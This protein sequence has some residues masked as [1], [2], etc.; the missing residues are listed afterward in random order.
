ML[1]QLHRLDKGDRGFQT[2]GELRVFDMD[3]TQIGKVLTTVEPAWQQNRQNIS[4][5][6]NGKFE[7]VKRWS[8]RY[9]NHFH[10][11]DIYG[12]SLMLFHVGN[13]Q[14]DTDGCVLPGFG[15]TDIDKDGHL[16]TVSSASAMKWLNKTLPFRSDLL[17]TS[18]FKLRTDE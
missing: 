9:G 17:I 3:F 4:C 6:P 5:G 13:F 2:L 1:T 18:E 8:E 10:V 16:D 15:F 12:R 7:L 14:K 11:I